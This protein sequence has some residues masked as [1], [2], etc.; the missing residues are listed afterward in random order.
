MA[1][2][3]KKILEDLLGEP[4]S[5]AMLLR[6]IRTRDDL[7]QKELADKLGVTVSHISDLENGRKFVS[8]ER[9]VGFAH[10]LKESERYFISLALQDQVNQADLD[11][12]VEIA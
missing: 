9:A 10:K 6:A 5:F 1:K 12:K 4:M 8:V 3:A 11:Y 2:N 7:T